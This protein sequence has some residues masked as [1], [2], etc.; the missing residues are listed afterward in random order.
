LTDY[1][2]PFYLDWLLPTGNLRESRRNAGRADVVI[3]T[4]CPTDISG[5]RRKSIERAIRKYTS[6]DVLIFFMYIHYGD[7]TPV[8]NTQRSIKKNII[9]VTGIAQPAPLLNYIQN[10][11]HLIRHFNFPDHHYFTTGDIR[12]IIKCYKENPEKEVSIVFTEKDIMRIAGTEL[13]D[14]LMDYPVFFQTITYKFAQNGSEF[15]KFIQKVIDKT[16]D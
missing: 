12:K 13:Q 4:K 16:E 3:V 9:L 8:F 2:R 15:D 1:N 14:I 5:S 6:N 7:P 11:F 10:K